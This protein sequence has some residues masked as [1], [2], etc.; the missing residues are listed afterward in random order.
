LLPRG[1]GTLSAEEIVEL[2][3]WFGAKGKFPAVK[4]NNG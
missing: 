4:I 2:E 3:E 1:E